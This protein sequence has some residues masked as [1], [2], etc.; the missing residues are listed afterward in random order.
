M[1][2]DRHLLAMLPQH[3]DDPRQHP[4]HDHQPPAGIQ[5]VQ[6]PG[7]EPGLV[8]QWPAGLEYD[9]VVFQVLPQRTDQNGV[10]RGRIDRGDVAD[11]IDDDGG[12]VR[13]QPAEVGAIHWCRRVGHSSL[14]L[15]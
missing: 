3:L 4:G 10:G 12:S 2:A 13:W 9:L 8:P 6:P 15:H 7:D 1:V 5:F 14:R 11:D